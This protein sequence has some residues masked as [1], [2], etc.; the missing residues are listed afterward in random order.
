MDITMFG[1][2]IGA[3][4]TVLLTLFLEGGHVGSFINIAS[5]FLILSGTFCAT[6]GCF[7]LEHFKKAPYFL[8]KAF[9]HKPED[10]TSMLQ[11]LFRLAEKA[12]REGL[13]SLEDEKESVENVF[14]KKGLQ[15]VVDGIDPQL[16]Q[17]ILENE[18][19]YRNEEEKIGSEIFLMAGGFSPTLGIVGTVMGLVHMLERLGSSSGAGSLGKAVAGAF[20]ATFFGIST[21]NLAWLPI[22][23]KL[24]ARAKEEKNM[25]LCIMEGVLAIQCGDNTAVLKEKLRVYFPK[26]IDELS[27]SK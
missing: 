13:L 3:V 12:R 4:C 21:A 7:P 19:D 11:T 9:F 15:L 23:T 25:L 1:G 8:K 24:K 17:K 5:I 6:M 26:E 10:P 18:I 14:F 16:I 20:I 27:S 22:A 2:I